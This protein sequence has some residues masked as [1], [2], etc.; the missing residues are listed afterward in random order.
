[1]P[2]RLNTGHAIWK[3]RGIAARSPAGATCTPW[4]RCPVNN[5]YTITTSSSHRW[6]RNWGGADVKLAAMASELRVGV[7][8]AAQIDKL[9][10]MDTAKLVTFSRRVAAEEWTEHR[11]RSRIV[12][13]TATTGEK[14]GGDERQA[15]CW[16][17]WPRTWHRRPRWQPLRQTW[18]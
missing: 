16:Q 7:G 17:R 14:T 11:A 10:A 12:N 2:C 13:C 1:V 18:R 3:D 4:L 8:M 5:S 9:A 15:S 6:P